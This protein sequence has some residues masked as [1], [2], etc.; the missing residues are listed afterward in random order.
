MKQFGTVKSGVEGSSDQ[1]RHLASDIDIEAM[2]TK[3][4]YNDNDSDSIQLEWNDDPTHLRHENLMVVHIQANI[5]TV[6]S[7]E[8]ELCMIH[9]IHR[10]IQSIVSSIAISF[11]I[12]AMEIQL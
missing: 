6:E 11:Y 8:D 3:A 7:A 10:F 4:N 5:E 2:M 12:Y 1:K 9:K